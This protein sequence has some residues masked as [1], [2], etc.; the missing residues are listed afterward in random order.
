MSLMS[1]VLLCVTCAAFGACPE[2]S[3]GSP[4]RFAF[5]VLRS[6]LKCFVSPVAT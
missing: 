5:C 4:F 3:E 1:W 2:R 6:A